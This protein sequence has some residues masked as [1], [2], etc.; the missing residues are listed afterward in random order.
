[1]D[2]LLSGIYF[3]IVGLAGSIGRALSNGLPKALQLRL[4][5]EAPQ[6]L[7]Y[8][9][10]WLHAVSV[11]ELLLATGILG[12]LR[13][14]KFRVHITTGTQAG[15]ELLKSRIFTWDDGSGKITG[16][17]FPLDDSG[18]LKSFLET[19]PAVF[20]ALETEVWPN[21]FRELESRNIPICIVNGRLTAR[22]MDSFFKPWLR[23][24][25]SCISIVSAK[26]SDSEKNFR[27]MGAPNVVVGGNLKSDLPAPIPLH[28][29]WEIIRKGWYGLP[30]LVAGNTVDGEEELILDAWNHAKEAYAQLRLI[31]APRQPKRFEYV[32]NLLNGYGISFCRATNLDSLDS[33]QCRETQVLL[34]DTL[35]ELASVYSIGHI[36]LIGGGWK[37]HG[38]HNPLESIY[39]G[40][41]TIIGPSYTNFEDIVLPLLEAGSLTVAEI[42]GL[43]NCIVK[44]LS[45][46]GLNPSHIKIPECLQGSL[47]K[48]W[49]CIE[50]YLHRP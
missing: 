30:I 29:G 42:A 36:A 28:G 22:T 39:W 48:T 32:A 31:I 10:I 9:W 7:G 3:T 2:T 8:G 19:P 21:L 47:Q 45:G 43:G 35:G 33:D 6:N 23:C 44:Q 11:G 13:E 37:W 38:G 49:S 25:I 5:A 24:A 27:L 16:G 50:P 41:P 34:L 14:N 17:A 46:R 12:K 15:L 26:D 18:G 4:Q 40:I 1:M 20:I